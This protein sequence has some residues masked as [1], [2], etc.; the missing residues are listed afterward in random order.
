MKRALFLEAFD[1]GLEHWEVQE[2]VEKKPATKIPL[3]AH[4]VVLCVSNHATPKSLEPKCVPLPTGLR[5]CSYLSTKH[6]F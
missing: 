5:A 6:P 1:A 4:P 3:H 2:L